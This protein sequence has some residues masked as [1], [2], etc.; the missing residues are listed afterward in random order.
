MSSL[1]P[2]LLAIRVLLDVVTLATRNSSY[3]LDFAYF[4][5]FLIAGLA[6]LVDKSNDPW[7]FLSLGIS[8]FSLVQFFI[9]RTQHL[10]EKDS[11]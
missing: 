6:M 1:I 9:R 5:V 2:V 11:L 8:L 3:R 10:R 7:G 4:L